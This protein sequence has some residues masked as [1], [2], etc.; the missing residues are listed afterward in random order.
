LGSIG[1]I[2]VERRARLLRNL[3]KHLVANLEKAPSGA[4]EAVQE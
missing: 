3:S 2:A 4:G 1:Q